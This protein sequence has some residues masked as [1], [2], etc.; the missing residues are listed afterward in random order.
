MQMVRADPLEI[1][2]G[3]KR[4]TFGGAARQSLDFFVKIVHNVEFSLLF[5]KKWQCNIHFVVFLRHYWLYRL[6]CTSATDNEAL[7]PG[8]KKRVFLQV[9]EHIVL[10]LFFR[11]S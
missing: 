6:D 4:T 8:G 11:H 10:L 3:T 5:Y 2:F 9:P 1:F 7:L